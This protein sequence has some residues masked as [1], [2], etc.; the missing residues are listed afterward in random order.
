MDRGELPAPL[1]GAAA[2]AGRAAMFARDSRTRARTAAAARRHGSVPG[3]LSLIVPVYNV[4]EYLDECLTSLRG[5]SYRNIE[6]VVVD[7]GTPD[8]SVRIARMH[9]LK[10]PRIRIV[11]RPNGGLSAARN[12]GV[13]AARGEFIAFAD[14]DDTVPPEGYRA[15]VESLLESGSDFS[16]SPYQRLKGGLITPAATWIRDAHARRRTGIT[17]D[18]FPGIQVNAIMCS[19]VFRRD[20]W[21]EKNLAFVEGIIY[22]DQQVSAEAYTRAKAF[23]VLTQPIYNWRARFDRTSISQNKKE[24]RNLRAQFAAARASVDVLRKHGSSRVAQER[25]VQLLSNDMALF[26]GLVVGANDEF[27]DALKDELPPLVDQLDPDL[28]VS[29]IP[30]QQKVLYHLIATGQRAAAE[31]LVRSGGMTLRTT[32]L[33]EEGAGHVAYLSSWDD[34]EADVPERYYVLS[35]GQTRPRTSIRGVRV[36]EPARVEVTAWAFLQ[37]VD[38]SVQDQTVRATA[39]CRGHDPVELSVEQYVDPGIDEVGGV[40]GSGYCDYRPGGVRIG[41]DL[42]ALAP[43]TWEV[44]LEISSGSVSR[45]ATLRQPWGAGTGSVRQAALVAPGLAATVS[46]RERRLEVRVYDDAPVA[47]EVR[48]DH[49]RLRLAGSGPAPRTLTATR[50]SGR[51]LRA[52]PTVTGDRWSAELDLT[53]QHEKGPDGTVTQWSF[54]ATIAGERDEVPVRY[55]PDR[56]GAAAEATADAASA[57]RWRALPGHLDQL[58]VRTWQAGA[59]VTSVRVEDDGVVVDVETFGLDLDRYEP[60]F[61]SRP[62]TVAAVVERDGTRLTCRLPFR[63]TRWGRPDQ[64][65]VSAPY[66]L[67]LEDRGTGHRVAPKLT[68]G[69]VGTLPVDVLRDVVRVR[70]QLRAVDQGQLAVVVS[71][72]LQPEERGIRNQLRLQER[73]NGGSGSSRSVFFRTLYGE[74]TNDNGLAVHEELRRRGTD[75]TL[76]W[77]VADHSVPV[78]EGAVPVLEESQAWHEALGDA[79]FVM[80]NVHQPMWYRKPERQVMVETFHGYPYKGMGQDWWE[81]SGLPTSRISSFLERAGDWDY[82]VSPAGYATPL[83]LD[84]FFTPE[85]AAR[86][87]VLEVGYPRNDVLLRPEGDEV[88]RRTREALGIRPDQKAVLYAPTFRDYL[89]SDGMTAKADD[90]FDPQAAAKALGPGYVVLQRGHAFHARALEARV[91]APGVVDVTY[92]PDIAELCLAS[93]SAILDYSSLR[94]DYAL[95]RKPMVFLVP[96]KELYHSLRPAVLDFDPTAP[97]PHVDTTEEAVAQ[98][99]RLDALAASYAPAVETFVATY[100]EHEDGHAAARVVDAVF[101]RADRDRP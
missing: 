39:V 14:S 7:D 47:E 81:R 6:I 15:A 33:G 83:L 61:E 26:S 84:A 9:R 17:V 92:Y 46:C 27:W 35:E 90:F 53:G 44:E 51:P 94:F 56:T 69:V 52:T 50:R 60:V 88:R 10:D 29:A 91:D 58:L 98:L 18:E 74:S 13:R 71:A 4:E 34:P 54:N 100:L 82:L 64:V 95:T 68:P 38:L 76:Y 24:A 25:L 99:R 62:R 5:Q 87:E 16:V 30:A 101:E 78:P 89:S 79:G 2:V 23:D 8:R 1:R 28:Y 59:Q 41:I 11:H 36:L 80:V 93:D 19:K 32:R 65:L 43:G 55:G 67:Q 96:D 63:E 75:L 20:F 70:L 37:N 97:G 49:G 66:S 86:V 40:T 57:L 73:A 31:R 21:L 85:D 12:T 77:A 45:T 3:L 72:P 48:F 22:E 42:T